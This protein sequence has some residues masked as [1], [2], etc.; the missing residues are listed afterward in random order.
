MIKNIDNMGGTLDPAAI[1]YHL[2]HGKPV[3]AEVVDKLPSDRGGIPAYL[4]DKLCILEEFR[5][6]PSFDPATVRV[7]ATNVFYLDAAMLQDLDMQ[8]SYFT[9]HKKV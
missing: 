7:F 5:I 8:W 3:T 4:D 6:P 2:A 1:G 9:V